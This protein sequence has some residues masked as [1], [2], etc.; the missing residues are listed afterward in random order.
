MNPENVL[1]HARDTIEQ[2]PSVAMAHRLAQIKARR[3][4]RDQ[5]EILRL[6]EELDAIELDEAAYRAGTRSEDE[7]DLREAARWYQAAALSDFPGASLKLA[8][9]LD[10]L[11][12]EYLYSPGPLTAQEAELVSRAA[13]WYLTAFAAGETDGETEADE[14]LDDF[15]PRHSPFR[16]KPLR[17][18]GSRSRAPASLQAATRAEPDDRCPLGGL[19]NMLKLQDPERHRHYGDCQ[20]CQS[21]LHAM[22]PDLVPPPRPRVSPKA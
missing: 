15:L 20:R 14:L 2:M 8:K 7:G 4:T 17:A 12:S 21:E 6:R 5:R 16:Q 22:L 11:A 3:E 10:F 13:H 18:A 1:R 19:Q 9:A